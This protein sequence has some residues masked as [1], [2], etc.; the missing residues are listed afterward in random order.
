MLRQ[1]PLF[2]IGTDD[3]SC[4]IDSPF[5]AQTFQIAKEVGSK[6]T[7]QTWTHHPLKVDE[8]EPHSPLS[9]RSV[10]GGRYTHACAMKWIMQHILI[11][12]YSVDENKDVVI[13][14]GLKL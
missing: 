14:S 3:F 5:S 9:N 4:T 12:S 6:T 1:L 11:I 8:K 2:V 7:E 10:S 13:A